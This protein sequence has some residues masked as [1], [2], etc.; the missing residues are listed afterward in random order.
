VKI[1]LKAIQITSNLGN[2]PFWRLRRL[3]R[4]A[5]MGA[6]EHHDS[7]YPSH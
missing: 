6:H 5:H 1:V 7:D 4:Q 2:I 3:L